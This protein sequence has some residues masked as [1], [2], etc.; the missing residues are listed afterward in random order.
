MSSIKEHWEN[1]YQTR[2]HKTVGWYQETPAISLQLLS[3][4]GAS[5]SQSIIDVGCGASLLVDHLIEQGY[6]KIL[7]VDISSE[8]LLTIKNRLGD[9]GDLPTYLSKDITQITCSEPYD[10][11]HDRAVFHFLTDE[12][13]RKLYMANLSACLA[14]KGTA[15]IGT[16][17]L[18]GPNTCSGL[19]IVQYDEAKMKLELSSD[20]QITDTS[21]SVHVMPNG[22]EQEYMYFIIK[23]IES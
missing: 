4:I 5:P 8:A 22:A 1:I 11:W 19:E 14:A 23:R 16:F 15:I 9:Q 20:L 21:V 12:A 10:L 3:E 18:N 6:K 7:L 13:D 17:S 2:D